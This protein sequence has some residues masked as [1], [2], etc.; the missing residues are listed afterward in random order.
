MIIPLRI[1]LLQRLFSW[2][3]AMKPGNVTN[4]R[5]RADDRCDAIVQTDGRVDTG[6][7]TVPL[8]PRK[9]NVTHS[10]IELNCATPAR[11]SSVDD[12]SQGNHQS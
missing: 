1:C 6:D 3:N 5:Y 10:S 4:N 8:R 7:R 12:R 9:G 11:T 2:R